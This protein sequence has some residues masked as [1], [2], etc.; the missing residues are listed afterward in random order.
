MF[1]CFINPSHITLLVN[2]IALTA[3]TVPGGRDIACP[4]EAITF[5]FIDTP[6]TEKL[7][8]SPQDEEDPDGEP[9]KSIPPK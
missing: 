9:G 4:S 7:L 1:S 8:L 3:L 2:I 6:E 5:A